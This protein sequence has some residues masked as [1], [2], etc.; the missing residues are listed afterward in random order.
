MRQGLFR[1]STNTPQ[2]GC[3]RS[4]SHNGLAENSACEQG[5]VTSWAVPPADEDD[6]LASQVVPCTL[7]SRAQSLLQRL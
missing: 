6:D 1:T 3:P 7:Q 5:G 4:R 2:A